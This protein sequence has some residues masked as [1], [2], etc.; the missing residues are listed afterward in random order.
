MTALLPLAVTMGEPAGIGGELS[1]KAW[2][3]RQGVARPFF[4]LDDPARLAALARTLNLKVAIKE[5]EHPAEA[6]GAFAA[7]L[8]VMPVRLRTQARPGQPDPA[9]APAT[10]EYKQP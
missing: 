5:I 8:P 2:L 6:A 3:A 1:L 4:V 10:I 9:N 7:A